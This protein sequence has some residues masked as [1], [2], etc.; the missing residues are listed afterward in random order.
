MPTGGLL[1]ARDIQLPLGMSNPADVIPTA[2]NISFVTATYV[3]TSRCE[4]PCL[5]P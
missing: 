4:N 2:S 1:V 3:K 5:G